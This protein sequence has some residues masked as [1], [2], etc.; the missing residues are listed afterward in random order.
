MRKI[1]INASKKYAVNIGGDPSVLSGAED[2]LKGEKIAVI[3]DE[4]VLSIYGNILDGYFPTKKIYYFSIAAGE[5]GKSP[6]NFIAILDY[7]A[8]NGFCRSDAIIAFGGGVAGDLAAFCASVYMRGIT[9]IAI[10]T[11]ILA[12]VDSSVGGKTAINLSV[13]KN[14]CGTF[15]Q[16]DGVFI[17]TGFFAT[18]PE[19]ERL[20]GLGE[21]I[22]YA[23]LSKSV[24]L[25][26]I[27]SGVNED[28]VSSCLEIKARIVEKDER[29]NGERKLLNLGHTVGHAIER[30]SGFTVSHGQCVVKGIYAILKA[31]K[32][33]YG[34]SE[35]TVKKGEKILRSFGHD[36]TN[37]YS[38]EEIIEFIRADKK[39]LSD[40]IDVVL[41]G[42]DLSPRIVNLSF[43][44]LYKLLK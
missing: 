40:S 29:D 43:D 2:L 38:A 9:L 12:A 34:Y 15:Y 30:A 7:L 16:P 42:E 25:S 3:T 18:L 33:Y 13:G 24:D 31:S 4:N 19:R 28:T 37:P 32:K 20:C 17:N 22:K 1:T 44:E 23:F 11:T 41:L 35:E 10:P 26:K 39:S 36:L 27:K 5:N 8:K 6:Q 14:L 21:I